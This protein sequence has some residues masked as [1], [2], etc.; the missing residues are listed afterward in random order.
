[1]GSQTV[2]PGA[3]LRFGVKATDP[4]AGETLTM[5]VLGAPSGAT[6]TSTPSTNGTVTGSF[7]WTPSAAQASSSYS[8]EF[9]ASDGFLASSAN[10]SI[11][12]KTNTAPS[13]IVPGA[14]TV[15]VGSKLTFIVSAT[16]PD[17][18][19]DFV[20]ISCDDC[21]QLGAS[22]DSSTGN[23]TWVPASE[24]G[25]G[26]R[27][28]TFTATDH[29]LPQ[30]TITKSV[31]VH[32]DKPTQPPSL[33]QIKDWTIND[34]TLL[35]FKSNATDPNIPPATLAFSLGF[36][37]PLGASISLDGVFYWTPTEVQ[38]GLYQFTVTVSNGALTDSKIVTVLVVEVEQPPVLTVPGPQTVG[39][40]TL[41][42]FSV[43][44]TNPDVDDLATLSASGLPSGA[45]FNPDLGGFVWTPGDGQGPSVYTVTFRAVEPGPKG[46]SDTKMVTITVEK[47]TSSS[48]Q[49]FDVGGLGPDLWLAAGV[50]AL[51]VALVSALAVRARRGKKGPEDGAM[52]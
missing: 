21:A 1:V 51:V 49:P 25:A 31:T 36:D 6:F 40:G 39:I 29:L 12:V 24:L 2:Y 5:V 4:D 27:F 15:N 10:A 38:G 28:A 19:P 33:A 52:I 14:Q 26:D 17:P 43:S 35:T 45:S 8:V 34:E 32:V 44:A 11:V 16:D 18:P 50:I 46:L 9:K 23:F 47:A 22:F 20:T 48:G 13:L 41:L 30:L 37:A 42:I 3:E 7:D